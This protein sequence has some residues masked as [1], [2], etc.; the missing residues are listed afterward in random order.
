MAK[1]RTMNPSASD[2]PGVDEVIATASE[3]EGPANKPEPTPPASIEVVEKTLS[4]DVPYIDGM[5]GYCRRRVDV[6]L[7]SQQAE[8]LKGIL[9]GLEA[10]DAKLGNGRFVSTQMHAVQWMIENL[11]D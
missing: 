8:T 2:L 10:K 9:H 5:V 1:K 6:T 7:T 3:R 11:S 4:C